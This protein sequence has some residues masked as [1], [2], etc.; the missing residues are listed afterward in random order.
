VRGQVDPT[1]E[2]LVR[3]ESVAGGWAR[4]QVL[5][6]EV[7]RPVSDALLDLLAPAA[8]ETILTLAAGPGDIGFEL[9][10]LVGPAGRVVISDFAP[11]MVAAARERAAELALDNVTFDVLDA[12][13]TGLPAGSFDGI[14]CRFGYM[15]TPDPARALRETARLLHRHGR[16]A[17]AVWDDRR[18]NRWGTVVGAALVELGHLERPDRFAP[19]PF[20][21][22]DEERMRSYLDAAGLTIDSVRQV[23][24]TWRFDTF[25]EWWAV[26]ADL[27]S[28]LH[29]AMLALT[30][31]ELERVRERVQ[32]LL[33]AGT[34]PDGLVLPGIARVVLARPAA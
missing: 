19:G 29:E 33:G 20:A 32:A 24:V 4:R 23:P 13:E 22:D 26:T 6:D 5:F 17:F 16:V 34:P 11:A 27:S 7:A 10:H 8:G 31:D 15:L 3:W 2:S 9:A 14:A 30:D 21:L 12:Q 1:A 28:L 25:D 18:R